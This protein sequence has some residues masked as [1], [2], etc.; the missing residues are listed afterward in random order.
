MSNYAS[1]D[2][3]HGCFF[4]LCLGC[5]QELLDDAV[6]KAQPRLAILDRSK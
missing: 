5:L 6:I 1:F 3:F 4:Q 2:C